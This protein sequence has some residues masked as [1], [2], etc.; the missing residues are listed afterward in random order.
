MNAKLT[1]R[2]LQSRRAWSAPVR[3]T[4]GASVHMGELS[5]RFVW[6]ARNAGDCSAWPEGV[7]AA[8]ASRGFFLRAVDT[9]A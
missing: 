6:T 7:A 1:S 3:T 5:H 9:Q 8:W 2:N 4:R